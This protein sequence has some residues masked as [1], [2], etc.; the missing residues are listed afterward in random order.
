MMPKGEDNEG[1]KEDD[2]KPIEEQMQ[3]D[4]KVSSTDSTFGNLSVPD[5]SRLNQELS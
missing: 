5:P 3:E 1:K 2:G 4:A